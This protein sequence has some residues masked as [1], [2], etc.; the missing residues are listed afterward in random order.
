[1]LFSQGKKGAAPGA[2]KS[3][4]MGKT[5]PQN[6][7]ADFGRRVAKEMERLGVTQGQLAA[8]CRCS[9]PVISS[10]VKGKTP[11]P[12]ATTVVRIA[13]ALGMSSE[14]LFEVFSPEGKPRWGVSP[15]VLEVADEGETAES[16]LA[17]EVR[18]LRAKVEA[19]QDL[20]GKAMTALEADRRGRKGMK[21]NLRL[22]QATESPNPPDRPE[23]R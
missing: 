4:Y 11:D 13:R 12:K 18:N 7:G 21:P 23:D 16:P 1:M 2:D 20:V 5:A 17:S 15:L 22:L 6:T 10:L 14:T 9:Q 19:L 3:A 8:A